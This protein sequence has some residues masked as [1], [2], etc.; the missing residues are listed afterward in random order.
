MALEEV[1]R[2]ADQVAEGLAAAHERGIVHRDLKPANLRIT[3]NGTVKILDFGLAQYA[4]AVLTDETASTVTIE[5]G[6]TPGLM[7]T[8]PYMAPEQI[9][10]KAIDKRVDIWAFGV[11]L[12]ELFTGATPFG[13]NTSAETLG[14]I[15]RDEPDWR[16]VPS[17]IQHLLQRCLEKDPGK[18][19]R[20]I[21]DAKLLLQAPEIPMPRRSRPRR[22]LPWAAGVGGV[23]LA[24]LAY[25]LWPVIP[26]RETIR[27]EFS[28]P[29]NVQFEN[30][31]AVSPDGR[32]VAFVTNDG[33]SGQLWTR[34]LDN[35]EA[36][37]VARYANDADA[38]PFW[39]PDGRQIAW[40]SEAKLRR[41]D[42]SG[43][44]VETICDLPGI[45]LG[46]SWNQKGEILFGSQGAGLFRVA[47][48]GGVPEMITTLDPA[49]Q[50]IGHTF[51]HFLPDGVHFLYV[52]RSPAPDHGGVYVGST[53]D[54]RGA[55]PH[56]IMAEQHAVTFIPG[57]WP[58]PGHLLFVTDAGLSAQ[59]FSTG[60]FTVSGAPVPIASSV[61]LSA[62][63][64]YGYFSAA[65]TGTLAFTP[66][67]H[68][69][70][71]LTWFD[72]EGGAGE[73]AGDLGSSL[74]LALAPNERSVATTSAG[75]GGTD[76]HLFDLLQHNKSRLTFRPGAHAPV[77]FPDGREIAFADVSGNLLRK[78][79]AGTA[80]P[81]RLLSSNVPKV[82]NGFS[83]DGRYL[84]F[85]AINPK[86]KADVF[87]LSMTGDHKTRPFVATAAQEG[88]AA[89]SPDGRFVAYV[90]NE[91]GQNEVYAR[92]FPEG[93]G[94]WQ[95]S[96]SG[97]TDPQWS[98]DGQTVYF[99]GPGGTLYAAKTTLNP[100][101]QATPPQMIV[102]G[103]FVPSRHYVDN[104]NYDID[105]RGRI[106]A[107]TQAPRS[108]TAPVFVE[109]GG[110]AEKLR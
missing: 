85:T 90:S 51:P 14:S 15:L 20:D 61:G 59:S 24:A 39:S 91:T 49:Q 45:A 82:P 22:W 100:E 48:S 47:V 36:T 55:A 50:E 46:G 107:I 44:P 13:G 4:A 89:F 70:R 95:I 108:R 30:H 76:I 40:F 32:K 77:W 65:A 105:S 1:L 42:A 8:V 3:A 37:L 81:E 110:W 97:G 29:E 102:A 57:R 53:E 2:I 106:L 56:R 60:S 54:D 11:T 26:A 52:R 72:P 10:G 17:E 83:A 92:S 62:D 31:L 68:H 80:D 69:D 16:R 73:P 19:L 28:T 71:Q 25:S 6:G 64:T 5:P 103:R 41:V 88:Q 104:P 9:R 96:D 98:R 35:L 67:I 99:I 23:A 78:Q 93:T 74:E 33:S 94:H 75:R 18:R 63:G 79:A 21:A 86:T 84:L 38:Y 27:F 87:V 58:H 66:G 101:F 34:S 12:Y 43:G 109:I 7:G